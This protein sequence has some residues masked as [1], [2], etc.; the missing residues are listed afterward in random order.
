MSSALDRRRCRVARAGRADRHRARR[1]RG[2]GRALGAPEAAIRRRGRPRRGRRRRIAARPPGA[3]DAVPPLR[4]IF[5]AL[6]PCYCED[7]DLRARRA[8][9]AG[10]CW[11][12]RR[13]SGGA[14]RRRSR[15]RPGRHPQ[16]PLRRPRLRRRLRGLPGTH[17]DHDAVR[18]A[19]GDAVREAFYTWEG[20]TPRRRG[21][22]RPRVRRRVA[23]DDALR[24]SLGEA[25]PV[26]RLGGDVRQGAEGPGLR[27]APGPDS[28]RGRAPISAR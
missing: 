12:S 9:R 27:R 13:R 22:L 18:T 21:D 6:S 20:L 1:R 23:L 15:S 5:I 19:V 7:A 14:R 8:A 16:A 17:P 3:G 10:L 2:D 24:R 11:S 28:G 26:R 25:S 4:R